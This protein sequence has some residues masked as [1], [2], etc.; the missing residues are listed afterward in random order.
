MKNEMADSASAP[1]EPG[2]VGT[3]VSLSITYE[4]TR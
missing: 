3:V 1:V 4:M 2:Q